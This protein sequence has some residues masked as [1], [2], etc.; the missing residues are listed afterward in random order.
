MAVQTKV[1]LEGN[2]F[3]RDPGRTLRQNVREMNDKLAA[4]MEAEV[5]EQV[6]AHA[7]SMPFYTGW[8]ARHVHGRNES[9]RGRQWDTWAVVSMFTTGMSASDAI[10]TQAAA[11]TI[12]SRWHPFRRVKS[13][14]YR[15]RPLITAN[16]TKG[17][18]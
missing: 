4:W 2:F 14:V 15:A 13:G 5:R 3:R 16:L 9:V 11:A 17:L 18:E 10:R 1:T 7:S 8:T 12:E 6:E